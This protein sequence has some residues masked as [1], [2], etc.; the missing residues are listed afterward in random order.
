MSGTDTQP[1]DNDG[2]EFDL[3]ELIDDKSSLFAVMGV[4]VAVAA[5]LSRAQPG[6]ITDFEVSFSAACSP[7]R[8]RLQTAPRGFEA[9][10][11]TPGFRGLHVF[12][13]DLSAGLAKCY[14]RFKL[15]HSGG[16]DLDDAAR[17]SARYGP[18]RLADR[19]RRPPAGW[20]P[21]KISVSVSG[22]LFL[23]RLVM[24]PDRRRRD[25]PPR[26]HVGSP[27]ASV[28]ALLC[29][30]RPLRTRPDGRPL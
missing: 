15:D 8:S 12:Q 17:R 26:H 5:Y 25:V 18:S 7:P 1:D 22:D 28:R 21:P 20:S 24:P 27:T 3:A 2:E 9:S 23:Q 14:D 10:T 19:L 11:P 6:P 16:L 4:F 29:R 30:G 13:T